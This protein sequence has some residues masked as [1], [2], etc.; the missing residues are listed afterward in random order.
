MQYKEAELERQRESLVRCLFGVAALIIILLPIMQ[1]M[2]DGSGV[3]VFLFSSVVFI[4]SYVCYRAIVHAYKWIKI[5][6]N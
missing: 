6:L 2:L 1:F 5:K 4:L 3:G